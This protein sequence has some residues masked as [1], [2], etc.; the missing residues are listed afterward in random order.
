M[1]RLKAIVTNLVRVNSHAESQADSANT[2][3][4]VAATGCRCVTLTEGPCRGLGWQNPLTNDELAQTPLLIRIGLFT[5]A[6]Y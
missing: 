5:K 6:L 3:P 2:R 4:A 1:N